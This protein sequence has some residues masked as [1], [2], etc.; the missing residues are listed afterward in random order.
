[1]NKSERYS[2][3]AAFCRKAGRTQTIAVVA[4][5][6]LPSEI[7]EETVLASRHNDD[8]SIIDVDTNIEIISPELGAVSGEAKRLSYHHAGEECLTIHERRQLANEVNEFRCQ[9]KPSFNPCFWL[10]LPAKIA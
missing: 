6:A 5:T 8:Q 9:Q 1:M 4:I 3:I 2:F 7:K 10:W